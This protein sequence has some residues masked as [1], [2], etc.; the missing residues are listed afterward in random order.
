MKFAK[1]QTDS[2]N[3]VTRLKRAW[4]LCVDRELQR[5]WSLTSEIMVALRPPVPAQGPSS[6]QTTELGVLSL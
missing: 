5:D 1:I 2:D 4:E 6:G 3:R